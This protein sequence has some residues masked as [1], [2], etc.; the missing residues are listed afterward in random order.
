MAMEELA[1]GVEELDFTGTG[2]VF[3]GAF[4]IGLLRDGISGERWSSLTPLDP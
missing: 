3:D 1:F 4:M 2:E